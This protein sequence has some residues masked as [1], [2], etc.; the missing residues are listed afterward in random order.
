MKFP[1]T[2]V[3]FCCVLLNSAIHSWAQLVVT[4]SPP[5]VTDQKAIVELKMKNGLAEPIESARAI[6]F[7]LDEQG[8]LVGESSKWVIG[9]MKNR[10]SLR[11]KAQTTFNFVVNS[12]QP[13][14]S[15]NITATITF[16][17]I[18]L[19]GGQM[20]DIKKDIQIQNANQ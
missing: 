14:V 18:S 8:K 16:D 3:I 10:P 12:P 6:C 1:V 11:P 2:V 19:A 4:V 20:A 17:Q 13:F 15:T 9:G 7:L 5:K